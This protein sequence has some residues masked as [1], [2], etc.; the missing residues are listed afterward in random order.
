MEKGRTKIRTRRWCSILSFRCKVLLCN[1]IE[2]LISLILR[3]G[4]SFVKDENVPCN[5]YIDLFAWFC[6]DRLA[7]TLK[8][9][10]ESHFG[11]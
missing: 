5:F 11:Y 8:I 1:F 4:C 10:E 7:M 3:Q 9:D 6:P 2:C